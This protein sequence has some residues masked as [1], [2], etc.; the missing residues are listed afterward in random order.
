MI[1]YNI[2]HRDNKNITE[3]IQCLLSLAEKANDTRVQDLRLGSLI[4]ALYVKKQGEI[5]YK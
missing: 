2:L 4:F 5:M 3:T 1:I